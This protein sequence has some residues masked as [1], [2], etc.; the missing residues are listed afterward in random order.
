MDAESFRLLYDQTAPG[1]RRYLRHAV[2]DRAQAD[3]IMQEAYF[4]ILKA[5]VPP[6]MD[7]SQQKNYLYKI[8]TNLIRDE[9]R[10]RRIEQIPET[11]EGQA[12]GPCS[13]TAQDVRSAFGQLKIKE[14]NLLWLAYVEGFRHDEVAQIVDTTAGSVRPMLARAR[15]K[16][17]RIW[18]RGRY[19]TNG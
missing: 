4:R 2:A 13:D 7:A 6:G 15:E 3:D 10:M 8:A 19:D 9:R 17:V 5:K 16:F 18:K 14:R 11:Y 12:V 1:L